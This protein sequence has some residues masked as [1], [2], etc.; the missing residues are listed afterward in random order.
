MD[1][2]RTFTETILPLKNNL[3]RYSYSFLKDRHKAE[4]MVQETMIRMWNIKEKWRE[5]DNLQGYCL[6]IIRHLCLD[7]LRKR[8][9]H[10]YALNVAHQEQST[11][12]DPLEHYSSKEVVVAISNAMLKLPEKQ[13]FCFHL[14]E[15]EGMT[16]EQI[17]EILGISMDQVKVNIF[18]ARNYIK[19]EILKKVEYGVQ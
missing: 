1:Y 14:R 7:E 19:K 3:M 9:N 16:Y 5:M 11:D 17:S 13:H 4:D 2:K 18:R 8:K 6:G 15:N 12:N 10:Y